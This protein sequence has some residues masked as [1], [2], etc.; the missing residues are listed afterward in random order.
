M[1]RCEFQNALL[2]SSSGRY[3][4]VENEYLRNVGQFSTT[5][6]ETRG[7]IL[8][9]RFCPPRGGGLSPTP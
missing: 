5:D 8:S 2:P 3:D 7:Q 9:H 4:N 6:V 1:P